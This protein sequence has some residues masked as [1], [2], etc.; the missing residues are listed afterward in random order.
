MFKESPIEKMRQI[1]R[2]ACVARDG[3]FEFLPGG[4]TPP[5][6]SKAITMGNALSFHYKLHHN[7]NGDVYYYSREPFAVQ[8]VTYAVTK[9]HWIRVII[10]TTEI[11]CIKKPHLKH[12]V[13]C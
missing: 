9:H 11:G 4:Q 10:I 8:H 12:I 3:L 2:E 6:I 1:Y 13:S 5:A 7:F